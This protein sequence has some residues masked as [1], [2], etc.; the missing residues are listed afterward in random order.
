MNGKSWLRRSAEQGKKN[1]KEM[2]RRGAHRWPRTRLNLEFLEDRTLLTATLTIDASN[3][4]SYI[5]SGTV[6]NQLTD[7]QLRNELYPYR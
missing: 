4:L 1:Q 3:G 2:N 7:H 5:G 6:A